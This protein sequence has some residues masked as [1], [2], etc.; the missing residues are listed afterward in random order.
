MSDLSITGYFPIKR[1][2][3]TD[4]RIHSDQGVSA[5]IRLVPDL[6]YRPVCHDCGSPATTVHSKGHRRHVRDLNL[7]D[8]EVWLDVEYRK[9]WCS[10]CGG[11]RVELFDFADSSSRVTHRLARYVHDLCKKMTVQDVA[12]HLE[13]NPKTVKAIDKAFLEKSFGQTDGH[14]LRVL[15][16]DEIALR[17]GHN[18]M[19]V[20]MDY[21]T[22][23]IV[24]MGENRDMETLD[25]FFAELTDQQK[26][27]IEAV[28]MDMWEPFIN[29]VKHHCP[30]AQIVFDFFHVVQAFGKVIDTVRRDEYR[31]ATEQEKKV[32]KGSRYLL[33]KNPENLK[34]DQPDRLQEVLALNKTLSVLY[35][36]RGQL[37]MLYYYSD[38]RTVQKMLDDWCRMAATIDHPDVRRFINRLRFFEYGILNHA[39]YPIGTSELEGANNK[40]KVIKR[41]A[42]GFHDSKYFALKVKQAFAA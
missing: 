38:R 39:D 36:L 1:M 16:I 20:I 9:I 22:G 7:A 34:D 18:Y 21:F 12:E 23:R 17:K 31:K 41:K 28:A 13:L 15:A 5:L 40:I 10:T 6:R 24:W 27:G 33:L 37:K 3:I 29:R 26:Q 2:K 19:T 35:V 4:Q 11:V 32:L 14:G 8:A 30:Q 25:R 42:Y